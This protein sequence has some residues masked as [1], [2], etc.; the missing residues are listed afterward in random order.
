MPDYSTLF[1]NAATGFCDAEFLVF[2]YWPE[3]EAGSV[4]LEVCPFG[5]TVVGGRARRVCGMDRRW[6]EPQV[7]DCNPGDPISVN[8]F[9]MFK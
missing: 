2:I 3:S 1:S 9:F 5:P 4:A 6:Q 8:E 7:D